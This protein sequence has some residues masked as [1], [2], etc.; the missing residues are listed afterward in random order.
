MGE[1]I[2]LG[3]IGA[4][5]MATALCRGVIAAGILPDRAV[6]ATDPDAEQRRRFEA[7]T[8]ART[9]PDNAE[10]C[11]AET[12]L[13][14]VKPHIVPAVL[15][16]VVAE[17]GERTLVMSVAAGV[18]T[19]QI[20][21]ACSFPVRVIRAMPNT[22]MLVGAGAVALS[23][24]RHATDDDLAR[25]T[26][27]FA[28]AA[29][30]LQVDERALHAVTALSGSGPAY[31]FYLA[32]LMA[33]AGVELGLDES[34]AVELANRTVFGAG[35]M[36]ADTGETAAA[37]RRQV[38]TPGGTT[39]AAMSSMEADQVSESVIRAIR[40]AARRSEELASESG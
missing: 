24:G 22:P 26:E 18:S 30:V 4:G 34:V 27:L 13:L 36:L 33:L 2:R 37:L 31:V 14:A 11:R 10:A 7:A 19:Q 15:A 16:E 35:K 29:S 12:L 23:R 6:L 40:A 38:T 8:G 17:L 25:A 5:S 1:M 32:E 21:S 9:A 20:E 28:T 3:V 39:A